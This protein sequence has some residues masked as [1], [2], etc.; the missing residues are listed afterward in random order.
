VNGGEYSL[1]KPDEKV[2]END[3]TSRLVRREVSLAMALAALVEAD[4]AP[5]E[6][7]RRMPLSGGEARVG[8]WSHRRVEVLAHKADSELAGSKT[9]ELVHVDL[10]WPGEPSRMVPPMEAKPWVEDETWLMRY[11]EF[12]ANLKNLEGT[13]REALGEELTTAFE[14]VYRAVAIDIDGTLTAAER[15]EVDKD[16][17]QVIGSLLQRSVPVILITGRGRSSARAAVA[18]I[19]DVVRLSLNQLRRLS[20]VTHNGVFRLTTD[21]SQP[22]KLLSVEELLVERVPDVRDLAAEA[23]AAL[24]ERGM[25]APAATVTLEPHSVR[26]AVETKEQLLSAAE[27]LR[28]IAE[29]ASEL[30]LYLATGEYAGTPSLD[31]GPTNKRIAL[32]TIA[33]KMGIGEENILRL[34]DQGQEG[35]NDFDLLDSR[36]GFSVHEFS[37]STRGCFPVVE[38]DG[39]QLTG[40]TATRRLLDLT[41]LFP[42]LSLAPAS[43]EEL[44]HTLRQ[45]NRLA[46]FGARRES[47]TARSR[48]RLRLN[49]LLSGTESERT[50]PQEISD[51]FDPGSGAVRFRDW[52]LDELPSGG[53]AEELFSFSRFRAAV[54]EPRTKWAM[55]TDTGVILRGPAYYFRLSEAEERRDYGRYLGNAREFVEAAKKIIA[56]LSRDEATLVRHKL[57]LGLL[58]NVRDL[59]LQ[60]LFAAYLAE[61]EAQSEDYRLTHR[62]YREGVRPHT[63][64]HF[65]LLFDLDLD[66]WSSIAEYEQ[67]LDGVVMLLADEGLTKLKVPSDV[68]K[69]RE[70]DHFVENVAAVQLGLQKIRRYEGVREAET[71]VA[72][73]IAYG[74]L[75]LPAIAEA[76]AEGRGFRIR[77]AIAR[78][79]I[80]SQTEHRE[81]VRA[82]G[83]EYVRLLRERR[84]PICFLDEQEVIDPAEPVVI[85]DDNC[86]T[87]VT[88]QTTRDMLVL[89]GADV[90]GAIVIRY[91]GVNRHVHMA[92]P[93]HGFP[94]PDVLFGFIRGLIGPSPYARLIKPNPEE[95]NEYV[96]QTGLFDKAKARIIRHLRKNGQISE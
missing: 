89:M 32:K 93:S 53:P 5:D 81:K 28:P 77:P 4:R 25:P 29:A 78:V 51:L 74:G 52:E 30:P 68:F 44:V 24:A 12:V 41:L 94:D 43:S 54:A 75:E 96:D 15:H 10:G 61:D 60:L 72:L 3:D 34:G 9:A 87:C 92:L 1:D 37:S 8:Q 27:A 38:G 67:V 2:G 59:L 33:D 58:D 80:Y 64:T 18:Q 69:F 13:D 57:L 23:E 17:A 66:W 70:A 49:F 88:I 76:V 21:P 65:R 56:E 83:G 40:V 85:M 63:R 84:K 79:S 47:K 90:A 91:P 46:V 73:G 62:V 22:A 50:P 20:C 39:T 36:A 14:T 6:R 35:G 45:F 86:T 42:P 71:L 48:I 11:S 19:Q 26:V 16:M 7:R 31:L 82:G 95:G 55:F